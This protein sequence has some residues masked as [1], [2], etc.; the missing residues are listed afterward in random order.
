MKMSAASITTFGL[1]VLAPLTCSAQGGVLIRSEEPAAPAEGRDAGMLEPRGAD[2]GPIRL[3]GYTRP[4]DLSVLDYAMGESDVMAM[5]GDRSVRFP[6]RTFFERW[7]EAS[8]LE[9]PE[10]RDAQVIVRLDAMGSGTGSLRLQRSLRVT[11]GPAGT[12]GVQ[13]FLDSLSQQLETPVSWTLVRIARRARGQGGTGFAAQPG[14]EVLE[15][16]ELQPLLEKARSSG[17]RVQHRLIEDAR[18]AVRSTW[19]TGTPLSYISDYEVK[20]LEGG[21]IC[22]PVV[23][24]VEE[25]FSVTVSG[26]RHPV[27]GELTLDLFAEVSRLE[28]P[29]RHQD[30]QLAGNAVRVQLPAVEVVSLPAECVLGRSGRAVRMGPFSA[31]G[32]ALELEA[33]RWE[34]DVVVVPGWESGAPG[35]AASGSGSQVLGY[36][37]QAAKAFLRPAPGAVVEVGRPMTFLRAGEEVARG[38]VSALEGGLVVVDVLD[39][40]PRAGDRGR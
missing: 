7:L 18:P 22:D 36:D 37:A 6:E 9:L 23:N 33:G 8:L 30:L 16:G 34:V 28:R 27:T 17:A 31:R 11:V 1:L 2:F 39:G 25:R 13:R 19:H 15:S 26:I 10:V 40:A 24:S 20:I 35:G 38:R 12:A 3:R 29:V 14:V 4:G 21:T 32:K 5:P